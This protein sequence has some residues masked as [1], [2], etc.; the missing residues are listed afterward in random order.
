LKRD[1]FGHNSFAQFS[2]GKP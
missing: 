2:A 1:A